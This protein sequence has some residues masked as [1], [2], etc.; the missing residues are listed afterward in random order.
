MSRA[1][2]DHDYK[3]PRVNRLAG[4]NL[5]DLAGIETGLAPGKRATANLVSNQAHFSVRTLSGKS[6]ILLA[7]DGVGDSADALEEAHLAVE[8]WKSR[9][10]NAKQIAELATA[11]AAGKKGADNCTV[12]VVALDTDGEAM[13][14]KIRVSGDRNSMDGGVFLGVPTEK[15]SR[16]RSSIS[17]VMDSLKGLRS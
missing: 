16:R 4:H 14:D 3:L 13:H 8:E 6:L 12:V 11:R 9:K 1:L 15:R 17:F 5:S 2:G 10:K 7:S